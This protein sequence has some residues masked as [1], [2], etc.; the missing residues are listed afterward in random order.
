M[1]KTTMVRI[2]WAPNRSKSQLRNIC[3]ESHLFLL[4]S[5]YLVETPLAFILAPFISSQL[6]H[7]AWT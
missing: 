1:S 2:Y 3:C 5:R 4:N 6:S 7:V